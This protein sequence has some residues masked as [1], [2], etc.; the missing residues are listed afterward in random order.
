MEY[1]K[2]L[3]DEQQY[4]VS[5]L[6]GP[7]LVIAGAGSGK[8]RVVTTRIIHMIRSGLDPSHI[9]GLTFTNK[10]AEEMRERVRQL[11][12]SHVLISTFHSL[13]ARILRESIEVLE[14]YGRNFAI[15][16]E[17]DAMKLIASILEEYGVKE[18]KGALRTW[19]NWISKAKN[20]LKEPI[21]DIP[22]E[23]AALFP[24]VYLAYLERLK[25]CNAVDFDDLLYL[26]LKI[27]QEHPDVL[28][29]YQMRWTHLLIDEYQDT[30]QVQYALVKLLINKTQNV[31][32]VGDPDQAIYSWRGANIRNILSFESDYP[33]AQVVRLEQNYRSRLI[34]LKAANALISKNSG[35]LEKNLWSNK[36]EGEKIVRYSAYNDRE[37]ARFVATQL[38]KHRIQGTSYNEM[39]VFYRTNAQSR[40]LEDQLLS[41]GIAYTIVGGISFYQRREIKDIMAYLRLIISDQDIVAF[42]RVI[43]TPK[44]GIG[45]TSLGKIIAHAQAEKQPILEFCRQLVQT[46][47]SPFSITSKVRQGLEQFISLIDQLRELAKEGSIET[48]IKETMGRSGYLIYLK[49]E[50]ETLEDRK[51]NLNELIVKAIEWDAQHEEPSLTQFIEELSL[52]SNIETPEAFDEKVSLMTLHNGKGLEFDIAFIVGLEED[53]LPHVNSRESEDMVEE[54]RRLCYVGM[55][56]AKEHLYL[57]DAKVR[58]LFG[59]E[60]M[61]RTSRFIREIPTEYIHV[62][63]RY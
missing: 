18:K 31:F 55:T 2:N 26:P 54:E 36:G 5:I 4:A 30:N 62:T 6:S 33:G 19:K 3:N 16:D 1:L 50:P 44:R 60:R 32:V 27:L 45:D 48:I 46:K 24:K 52:K 7:V 58:F 34:I 37:E 57:T 25:E 10:A 28:D 17:E 61:Q 40:P 9:L 51:E 39:V 59:S 63:T 56:R 43:N 15:Y 22:S 41:A 53:L 35:R 11:T 47:N 21:D 14:G 23:Y 49:E 13:G 38:R 20:E 12:N 29:R 42:S 8:T